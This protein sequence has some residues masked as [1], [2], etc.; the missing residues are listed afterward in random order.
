[1]FFMRFLAAALGFTLP[2]YRL[3]YGGVLAIDRQW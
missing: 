1:M 3:I 2:I